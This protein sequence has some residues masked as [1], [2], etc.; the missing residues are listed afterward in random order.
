MTYIEFTVAYFTNQHK[1]EY[2]KVW[3]MYHFYVPRDIFGL[4]WVQNNS[5]WP[6][7]KVKCLSDPQL[8]PKTHDLHGIYA[9]FTDQPIWEYE[10][11]C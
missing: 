11:V 4:S 3:L 5:V 10:Q 2:E 6:K 7:M 8:S 9:H 1:W